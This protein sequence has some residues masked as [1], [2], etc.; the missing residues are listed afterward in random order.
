MAMAFGVGHFAFPEAQLGGFGF[1]LKQQSISFDRPV[2]LAQCALQGWEL[3]YDGGDH[4]VRREVVRVSNVNYKNKPN[5]SNKE[6]PHDARV[7]AFDLFIQLGDDSRETFFSGSIDV[8]VIAE[9]EN[10]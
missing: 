6:S 2:T 5:N 3:H 4:H 1:T 9:V 7:V 8:L 10:G